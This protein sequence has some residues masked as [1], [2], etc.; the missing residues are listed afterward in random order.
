MVLNTLQSLQLAPNAVKKTIITPNPN[1]ATAPT[2]LNTTLCQG[3]P[4]A[5]QQSWMAYQKA[6]TAS[7]PKKITFQLICKTSRPDKLACPRNRLLLLGHHGDRRRS[8]HAGLF[9]H[10]RIQ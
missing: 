3:F 1:S 7:S 4:T 6:A 8:L 5:D 9:I 2:S 10:P